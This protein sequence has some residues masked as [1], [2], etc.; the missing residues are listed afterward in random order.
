MNMRS[1]FFIL[2]L[3]ALN[4]HAVDCIRP[5]FKYFA[6]HY[7]TENLNLY[8][9]PGRMNP[10]SLHQEQES[11]V[12]TIKY[13]WTQNRLDSMTFTQ[14]CQDDIYRETMKVDWKV[15]SSK[16]GKLMKYDWIFPD[17]R[18]NFTVFRG[19][20]SAAI[21]KG[22]EQIHSSYIK[23]DTI[24]GIDNYIPRDWIIFRDPKNENRCTQ[25]NGKEITIYEFE[26]RNNTLTLSITEPD[27]SMYIKPP[28]PCEG[29]DKYTTI[30]FR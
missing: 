29:G 6:S 25:V 20:D 24:R 3:V 21:V 9:L 28:G 16:V 7:M 5:M 15:D 18:D 17:K 22:R 12:I 4:A 27:H 19:K 23:N 2:A 10:D 26:K 11:L 8:I 30:F 14:A 13:H 1:V